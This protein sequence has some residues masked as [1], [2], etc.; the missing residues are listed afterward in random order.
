MIADRSVDHILKS[1]VDKSFP[2][3]LEETR[4]ATLQSIQQ[5][6]LSVETFDRTE[7]GYLVSGKAKGWRVEI[8]LEQ[9]GAQVTRMQVDVKRNFFRR[10]RAT[11]DAIVSETERALAQI[12]LASRPAPATKSAAKGRPWV[13]TAEIL[14]A[15]YWPP[16]KQS[17]PGRVAP[18]PRDRHAGPERSDLVFLR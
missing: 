11:A 14:R 1:T 15:H 5:M 16:S 6:E 10:D 8:E 4:A 9:V 13:P 17:A 12:K 7:S 2:V 3:P 18:A